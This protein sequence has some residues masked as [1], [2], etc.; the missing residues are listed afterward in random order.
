[1]K[2]ELSELD[3][4]IKVKKTTRY[5]GIVLK[6][7]DL[8]VMTQLYLHISMRAPSVHDMYKCFSPSRSHPSISNRLRRLIN[9]GILYRI[10]ENMG[11][12]GGLGVFTY[13]HYRL[14]QRGM[15]VLIDEG[16]VEEDKAERILTYSRRR[17]I[18]TAHTR[19]VSN[20]ANNIVSHLQFDTNIKDFQHMRGS[21]HVEF[22]LTDETDMERKG[23]IVPDWIFEYRNTIVAVE[24]D[25]GTQRGKIISQKYNR[26]IQMAKHLNTKGKKI[27]VVFAVTDSS[28]VD[29]SVGKDMRSENRVRRV[30][31]LKDTFPLFT[32][33]PENFHVFV[34]TANRVPHIVEKILSG[35]EPTT[36]ADSLFFA[37][38]W[39]QLAQINLSENQSLSFEEIDKVGDKWLTPK[40]NRE[41]DSTY[42]VSQEKEGKEINRFLMIYGNEGSVRSYQLLRHNI[43]LVVQYDAAPYNHVP[44]HVLM[45]YYHQESLHEEV[46]GQEVLAKVF[47]T[48][49]ESMENTTGEEG[50]LPYLLE[51]TSPHRKEEVNLFR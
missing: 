8:F 19:T 27:V 12:R 23:L 41:M 46:Y 13:Y 43:Q 48:D 33:W 4:V 6:Q 3:K 16:L 39:K 51:L 2:L 20:L 45:M 47:Y 34:A 14:A 37:D 10:D 11:E 50:I 49:L 22:G 40:R 24:V 31:T 5:T 44:L 42:L 15:S 38:T 25:T 35:Q 28:I 29:F 21:Q 17:G 7:D 26:Y 18:P 32:D 9:A 30:A 1:M 36:G